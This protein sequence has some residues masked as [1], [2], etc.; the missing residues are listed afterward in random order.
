MATIGI[1]VPWLSLSGASYWASDGTS[2]GEPERLTGTGT[3]NRN[4]EPERRTGT[5][6]RNGEPER[7]TGT[8]TLNNVSQKNDKFQ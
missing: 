6:N 7:R 3:E 5:E 4:G 8:G 1:E 2:N